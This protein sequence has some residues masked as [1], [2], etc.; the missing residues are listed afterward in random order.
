MSQTKHARSL[1]E[2]FCIAG[3]KAASTPK[4]VGL[5]LLVNTDLKPTNEPIYSMLAGNVIYLT[6]RLNLSFV[7]SY[8]SRVMTTPKDEHYN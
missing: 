2:R 3:C 6:T 8:M 5:K 7:V 1:L 4:E